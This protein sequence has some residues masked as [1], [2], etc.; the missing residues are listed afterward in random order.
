M[1]KRDKKETS[2]VKCTGCQVQ[3]WKLTNTEIRVCHNCVKIYHAVGQL[4][5]KNKA[6]VKVIHDIN[7]QAKFIVTCMRA[8]QWTA[9]F[10]AKQG[11]RWCQK[12]PAIERQERKQAM[13]AE[14]AAEQERMRQHQQEMFADAARQALYLDQEEQFTG[15]KVM[16]SAETKF[17]SAVVRIIIEGQFTATSESQDQL[18]NVI[19]A[20]SEAE[21]SHALYD[22]VPEEHRNKVTRRMAFLVH[23]DKNGHHLAKEAFQKV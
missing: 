19:M 3:F 12:C 16:V 11:R 15:S 13:M 20:A 22:Q 8:H 14:M 4:V 9:D 18:V 17:M 5:I 7:D 2:K 6:N 23:P 10:R 21:I 1:R